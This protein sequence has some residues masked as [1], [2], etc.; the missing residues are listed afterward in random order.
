MEVL[1][2]FFGLFMVFVQATGPPLPQT[3]RA[4][5]DHSGNGIFILKQWDG[6]FGWF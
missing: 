3:H 2:A 5:T 1:G 6:M 4:R